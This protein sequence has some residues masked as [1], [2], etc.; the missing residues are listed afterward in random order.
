M[1]GTISMDSILVMLNSLG[2][3]EKA[4]LSEQLTAQVAQENA[5]RAEKRRAALERLKSGPSWKEQ[6][7][8]MYDSVFAKFNTDWGG[9][10]DAMEIAE[11][12]HDSRANTRTVE[13]W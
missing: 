2:T 11:E 7:Q 9:E 1:T 4:W 6:Y 13:T 8:E 12:L 3:V 5:E 10:G